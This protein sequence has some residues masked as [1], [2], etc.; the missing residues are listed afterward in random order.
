MKK[1]SL[2]WILILCLSACGPVDYF[3]GPEPLSEKE[4]DHILGPVKTCEVIEGDAYQD[5]SEIKY[6][7]FDSDPYYASRGFEYSTYYYRFTENGEYSHVEYA[8]DGVILTQRYLFDKNDNRVGYDL[9]KNEKHIGRMK[10]DISYNWKKKQLFHFSADIETNRYTQ[11]RVY[12]IDSLRRIIMEKNFN[13]DLKGQSIIYYDYADKTGTN[14]KSAKEYDMEGNLISTHEYVYRDGRLYQI[15]I[16][17]IDLSKELDAYIVSEFSDYDEY[18]NFQR[19]CQYIVQKD[20]NYK[21]LT[22]AQ[23]F[24]YTYYK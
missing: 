19:R 6:F 23:E 20:D 4:L 17:D 21:R 2:Y 8:S 16:N 24:K 9:Y 5:G 18:G 22:Y 11:K 10:V 14:I 1:I 7:Y 12:Q 15:I 13:Q 3:A